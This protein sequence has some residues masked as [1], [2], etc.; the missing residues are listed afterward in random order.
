MTV[1]LFPFHSGFERWT[2]LGLFAYYRTTTFTFLKKVAFSLF[3]TERIL[4]LRTLIDPLQT[5]ARKAENFDPQFK[6]SSLTLTAITKDGQYV[7][8][9]LKGD[10]FADFDFVNPNFRVIQSETLIPEQ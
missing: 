3:S 4:G 8:D 9:H 10:E 7:L 1:L 6:K 5:D 2:V